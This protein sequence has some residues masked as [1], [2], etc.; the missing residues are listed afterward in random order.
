[1]STALGI[2]IGGTKISAAV[3]DGQTLSGFE[4]RPT[5]TDPQEF[6]NTLQ[7]LVTAHPN[8]TAIGVATAG[9]VSSDGTILGA[10]GNLPALQQLPDLKQRLQALTQRPV[11]IENDANAAAYGECRQGAAQGETDML[12]VTLGTG[13][14]TGLVMHNQLVRG[15]HSHGAEGGHI[16]LRMG[17]HRQ[18]TCG[19]WDCWE[20]YASGT[21]LKTTLRQRLAQSSTPV[22]AGLEATAGTHDLFERLNDPLSQEV[23]ALWH[24]HI[25][26]GLS[27]LL[28]L[29][30]PGV[31]VL[32]GGLA[33]FVN[34]DQLQAALAP[35]VFYPQPRLALATL[36]N[37]AGI[38]GAAYLA[39]GQ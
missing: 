31:T 32:G 22:W 11:V 6:L 13:V 35:R 38:V 1:M 33:K 28:N 24:E 9:L 4:K 8:I 37:Q 15:A 12:M 25:A 20:A 27:G 3:W 30:D 26:V 19:R 39:L 16:P 17:R 34:F 29:L 23:I 18:C 2:D 7:S 10:T 5:P 21:G 14:G 36:G